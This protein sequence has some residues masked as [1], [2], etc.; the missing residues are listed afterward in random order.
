MVLY[1]TMISYCPNKLS[2]DLFTKQKRLTED[3]RK[4]SKTN[5]SSVYEESS[6]KDCRRSL[7]Q[8][9]DAAAL[10]GRNDTDY[11]SSFSHSVQLRSKNEPEFASRSL[12]HSNDFEFSG[13]FDAKARKVFLDSLEYDH[14]IGNPDVR[15]NKSGLKKAGSSKASLKQVSEERG[16]AATTSTGSCG[17]H[18]SLR[19]GSSHSATS[20]HTSNTTQLSAGKRL[21]ELTIENRNHLHISEIFW[22]ASLSFCGYEHGI[23]KPVPFSS[24]WPSEGQVLG[25]IKDGVLDELGRGALG[26]LCVLLLAAGPLH[27]LNT[28]I[29]NKIVGK[30]D[31]ILL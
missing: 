16:D 6:P 26:D 24:L 12:K 13:N 7:T 28:L 2:E 10:P 31:D 30:T 8:S 25:L 15:S 1:K 17:Q 3:K 5:A 22:Y 18:H 9:Y 4:K 21:T 20:H 11:D 14:N 19:L 23:S 29:N 27:T